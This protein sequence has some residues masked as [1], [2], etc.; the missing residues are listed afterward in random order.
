VLQI[1]AQ[2]QVPLT[3]KASGLGIFSGPNPVVYIP[4]VRTIELSNLHSEIWSAVT[5]YIG[6]ASVYY[7]PANWLPHITIGFS[8]IAKEIL[9]SLIQWL[10][11]HTIDWDITID[12]F[13]LIYD[14]SAGQTL[15]HRYN[16]YQSSPSSLP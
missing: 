3:V 9:P 8:D 11:M 2:S 16:F 12:D 7:S 4:I 15:R 6:G 14:D 5:P 1:I 13:G 10:N